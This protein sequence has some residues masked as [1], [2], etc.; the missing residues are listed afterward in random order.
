MTRAV[1]KVPNLCQP[2]LEGAKAC[3]ADFVFTAASGSVIFGDLV[4]EITLGALDFVQSV[5]IDNSQNSQT[6]TL[7]IAGILNNGQIINAKP[8]SQGYYQ[9]TPGYGPGFR[10]S[11]TTTQLLDVPVAFYNIPMPYGTW[12]VMP[13]YVHAAPNFAPLV[14]GDNVFGPAAVAGQSVKLYRVLFTAAGAV[15]LQWFNGPSANL[16]P[17]SGLFTLFAG[18]SLMLPPCFAEEPPWLQTTIGNALILNA[19]AA[20][21]LGGA[22]DYIQS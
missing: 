20:V 3:Q 14:V 17:L 12:N 9:V 21:Q 2:Y 18:G 11:G 1:I 8:F 22:A 10:F 13:P 16:L 19:S 6:F 15:N 4:Q 5:W 7:T